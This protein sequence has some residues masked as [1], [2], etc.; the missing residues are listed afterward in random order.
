MQWRRYVREAWA[1]AVLGGGAFIVC[2]CG[3]FSR[4]LFKLGR[5]RNT[6]KAALNR[7]TGLSGE[8]KD[9]H[10]NSWQ[11]LLTRVRS[12]RQDGEGAAGLSPLLFICSGTCTNKTDGGGTSFLS[13]L[14]S[15][16][17]FFI[18]AINLLTRPAHPIPE[19]PENVPS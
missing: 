8:L 15:F 12:G 6:G 4:L 13:F 19:R 7:T 16:L 9:M 11:T 14:F 18:S 5:Q 2:R 17:L 1:R 10:R 3:H